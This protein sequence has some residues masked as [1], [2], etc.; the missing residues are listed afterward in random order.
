M[1]NNYTNQ[2]YDINQPS[3]PPQ[4]NQQQTPVESLKE[5]FY[6][7]TITSCYDEL[8][9]KKDKYYEIGQKYT[10]TLDHLIRINT[11][12]NSFS[13][14][15]GISGITTSL[16]G[17]GLPIGITLGSIAALCTISSSITT[18]I[19]KRY[20]KKLVKNN[21]ILDHITSTLAIFSSIIHE[22]SPNITTKDFQILKTTH[23]EC[24]NTIK[25]I[26]RNMYVE[27]DQNIKF[28]KK[29]YKNS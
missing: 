2:D 3:A 6:Q 29:I 18:L 9:R 15:S 8:K 20:K 22:S 12:S 5:I 25:R 26:K 23:S 28:Q 16:T 17:V 1:N 7:P 14:T 11:I 27:D 21:T 19:I 4:T 10:K 13:L 24:M